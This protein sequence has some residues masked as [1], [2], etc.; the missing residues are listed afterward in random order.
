MTYK[1]LIFDYFGVLSSEVASLWFQDHVTT[2][3]APALKDAYVRPADKGVISEEKL[4]DR[5]SVLSGI[6]PQQIP[7]QWSE[8][9]QIN[10]ELLSFIRKELM[11]KYKLGILTNATSAF[12]HTVLEQHPLAEI[13]DAI[14]I[15]SEIGYAKPE[16][17]AYASILRAL[18]VQPNEALMID[19]NEI[20]ITGAKAAGLNGFVFSSNEQLKRKLGF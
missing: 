2:E 16:Q 5:L 10:G 18:D 9:V 17:E 20:N 13:F 8:S 11:G 12:F 15:S 7:K 4:F 14:I 1:A 6:P 19:D 3:N